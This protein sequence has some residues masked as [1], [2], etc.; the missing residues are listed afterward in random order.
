MTLDGYLR[1]TMPE[2][3]RPEA[4]KLLNLERDFILAEARK[5]GADPPKFSHD[6]LS[7]YLGITRN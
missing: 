3:T 5:P 4:L 1:P 6:D 7:W 2:I